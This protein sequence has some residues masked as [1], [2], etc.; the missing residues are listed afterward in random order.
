MSDALAPRLTAL[1]ERVLANLPENGA[2]RTGALARLVYRPGRHRTPTS[3]A[4]LAELDGILRGLEHLGL[5]RSAG[6]WWRRA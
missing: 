1:D 3:A 4:E 5:A 2:I 6:G